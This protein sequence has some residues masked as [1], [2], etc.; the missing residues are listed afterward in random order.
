MSRYSKEIEEE[1]LSFWEENRIYEKAK[2][3]NR[4]GKPFF[5]MDVPPY[6]TGNIHLG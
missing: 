3:K 6:A 2:E 5:F 1:V 4:G